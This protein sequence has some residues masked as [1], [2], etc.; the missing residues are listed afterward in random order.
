MGQLRGEFVLVKGTSLWDPPGPH[1]VPPGDLPLEWNSTLLRGDFAEEVARLR[2][3]H[4]LLIYG[5]G[6]LLTR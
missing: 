1:P 3:D 2:Q 6:A 4:S 5:S